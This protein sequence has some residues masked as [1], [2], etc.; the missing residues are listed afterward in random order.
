M[1]EFA[2]WWIEMM[3]QAHHAC[4][5]SSN[6]IHPSIH[7][8]KSKLNK[9]IDGMRFWRVMLGFWDDPSSQA[10]HQIISISSICNLQFCISALPL[11]LSLSLSF[12]FHFTVVKVSSPVTIRKKATKST[13]S[14]FSCFSHLMTWITFTLP[15]NLRLLLLSLFHF[16]MFMLRYDDF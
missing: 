13:P 12:V 2:K 15:Y 4:I 1:L 5:T 11:S 14:I 3:K 8:S 16:P 6:P 10:L 7:L 9:K